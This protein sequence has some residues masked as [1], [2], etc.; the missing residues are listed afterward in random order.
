[1]AK[2]G[3]AVVASTPQMSVHSTPQNHWD[4]NWGKGWILPCCSANTAW[5]YHIIIQIQAFF[6]NSIFYL[7]FLSYFG[8]LFSLYYS[9]FVVGVWVVCEVN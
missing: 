6:G 7:N 2:L 8:I 4:I 9:F 5:L 1:M 3:G